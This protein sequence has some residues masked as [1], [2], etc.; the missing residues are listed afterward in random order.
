MPRDEEVDRLR[1]ENASLKSAAVQRAR[2]EL[3]AVRD[4]MVNRADMVRILEWHC[5]DHPLG[6][7]I[8]MTDHWV[9]EI[10]KRIAALAAA[11]A[12]QGGAP[13][14]AESKEEP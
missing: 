7:A 8:R 5:Q 4:E 9:A 12:A 6:G 2:E 14:V 1:T 13:T 10:D 3:E 11:D